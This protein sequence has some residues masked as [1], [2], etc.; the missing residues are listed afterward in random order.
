M[1]EEQYSLQGRV[2]HTIREGIL[3][4]RYQYDEELRETAI[5]RELGVSRTPVREALRQLELEGLVTIIP[6]KGAY[7]TGITQEDVKDIYQIRAR[8]E[9]LC[10]RMACER[11]T[12]EQLEEMEEVIFLSKFHEKKQNFDQL[13]TLDS[14][15]HEI[16]FK[17]GQSK[18]LTP[19]LKNLHQYV[20]RVRKS[21]LASGSRAELST[22]EHEQIMLAIRAKDGDQADELATRH[23]LNSINN[24]RKMEEKGLQ[25]QQ[26]EEETDYGKNEDDDTAG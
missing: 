3:N 8:L 23:I 12:K 17:A 11:I 26:N 16:L 1:G 21:S 25:E 24:I 19:L 14:R 2:F 15:F 13:V 18:M 9:G 20:Q 5:G 10:A 4:G 6:N 22:R 7:V